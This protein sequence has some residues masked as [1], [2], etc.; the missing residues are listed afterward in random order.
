MTKS[1]IDWNP[2]SFGF[3]MEEQENG[4]YLNFC[5]VD[6]AEVNFEF[7]NS[8]FCWA[9]LLNGLKNYLEKGIIIPFQE[10]N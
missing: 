5:H 7:K 4:T 1:D 3:D 6:W 2:T 8:S 9:M 10:R